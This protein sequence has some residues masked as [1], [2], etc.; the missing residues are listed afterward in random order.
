MVKI[1]STEYS[2]SKF[3]EIIEKRVRKEIRTNKLIEKKDRILIIDNNSPESV[4]SKYLL[5]KIIKDL[6]VKIE[7]KKIDFEIGMN[8]EGKYDKIIVPW[9]IDKEDEY[10]LNCITNNIKQIY[11]GNYELKTKKYVKLLLPLLYSEI[12][13][14]AKFK[15]FKFLEKDNQSD[16]GNMIDSLEK[17]Y[18]EI[19]FSLLK[20]IKTFVQTKEIKKDS[21]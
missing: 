10:F 3:L 16:V 21:S 19:K 9:C 6:P 4:V 17:E 8:I 20:S 2:E 14:Y 11:L 1:Q 7:V 12:V 15:K 5:K 13:T 18:P